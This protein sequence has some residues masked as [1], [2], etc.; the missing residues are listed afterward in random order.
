MKKALLVLDGAGI[1]VGCLCAVKSIANKEPAWAVVGG[2][3]AAAWVLNF[4][5]DVKT[6]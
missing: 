4:V 5:S 1:L 2:I 6:K 3:G